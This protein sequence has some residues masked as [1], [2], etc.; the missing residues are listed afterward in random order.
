MFKAPRDVAFSC[1]CGTIKGHIRGASPSTGTHIACF[2]ADCRAGDVFAGLPDPS[3]EPVRYFQTTPDRLHFD[4]GF[5]NLSVFSF[6]PKNLLRW[7]ASCCGSPL[8]N[9]LRTPKIAFVSIKSSA[10]ED[11]AAIGPV[12]ASAFIPNSAGTAKHKGMGRSVW[13]ALSRIAA[14]RVTGRWRKNPFFD[15]ETLAPVCAVQ[16]VDK[17][18][19][20]RIKASLG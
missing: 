3:P 1:P 16:I 6:G 7:Q 17:D 4:S 8:F 11:Q 5:E 19:R 10:L 15:A 14:A 9:T 20:A 13:A 2:C 12:R 18:V